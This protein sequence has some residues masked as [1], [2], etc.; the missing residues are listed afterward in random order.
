MATIDRIADP[1][2]MADA[3]LLRLHALLR[4]RGYRFVTPTPATHARVV[5]RADR[6][7]AESVEDVLGWSLPFRPG[8]IDAQVEMLLDQAGLLSAAGDRRRA[9][10]R[11]SSLHDRLFLHSAYPT[12]D[13]QAVFFGP[14][15][16]RFAD[17]VRDE[18]R[19]C[20]LRPGAQAV[21]IGAGSGVGGIVAAGACPGLRL[22]MTDRNPAALRF[23]RI[24]AQAAGIAAELHETDTLEP[25]AGTFDLAT[26]NPPYIIDG[27]GR[28]Y[29]DG[30]A[31]HGGQVSL[32]MAV[33]ALRR[34][35]P[36]GRLILYTGSAI[37]RGQDALRAALAE[38]ARDHGCALRYREIDPDVFGEELDDPVYRDVDRIA[39][40]AAILTRA[41]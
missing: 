37:V 41:R 16:Y 5:A 7:E 18:L 14:D 10:I 36:A 38:A 35:A 2:A 39:L 11:M 27:K 30:G 15:S 34:L 13:E 28:L 24:N 20:P 26:A 3:P 29:R 23:A 1:S 32:D 21:D 8:T 19:A 4:D 6:Q 22:A 25:V 33:M 12:D 40:V 31:M 9:T 17:L